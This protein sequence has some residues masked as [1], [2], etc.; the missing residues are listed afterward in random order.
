MLVP[1]D[2]CTFGG[3][4]CSGNA[5]IFVRFLFSRRLVGKNY[6]VPIHLSD[7]RTWTTAEAWVA[8]ANERKHAMQWL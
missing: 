2:V 8:F 1:Q 5:N 4:V 3:G 6:G 7:G